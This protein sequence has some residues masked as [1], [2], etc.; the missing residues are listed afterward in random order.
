MKQLHELYKHLVATQKEYTLIITNNPQDAMDYET[1]IIHRNKDYY[2]KS[3]I[4]EL[5]AIKWAMKSCVKVLVVEDILQT[6]NATR[7]LNAYH[8]NVIDKPKIILIGD[9]LNDKTKDYKTTKN[10]PKN[11][12]SSIVAKT[13]QELLNTK[14]RS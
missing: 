7:F 3:F 2:A 6:T 1:S 13:V 11:I 5:S 8:N 9:P 4:N 14:N 12:S 10:L